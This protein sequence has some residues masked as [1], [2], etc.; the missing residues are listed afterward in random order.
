MLIWCI[1]VVFA[2]PHFQLCMA[3]EADIGSQQEEEA[4][5]KADEAYDSLE[6][7]AS[8]GIDTTKNRLGKM[9]VSSDIGSKAVRGILQVFYKIYQAVKSVAGIL[10][11]VSEV[12]GTSIYVLFKKDKKIKRLGLFG[13][14][15][16]FPLII[17]AVVYGIGILNG[18]FLNVKDPSELE[19]TQ[20]YMELINCYGINKPA[21]GTI[22]ANGLNGVHKVYQGMRHVAWL[23]IIAFESVGIL[24]AVFGKYK[25]SKRRT[26]ILGYCIAIPAVLLLLIFGAEPINRIFLS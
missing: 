20:Q 4:E 10:I 12:I 24:K 1:A 15:V 17:V 23:L 16:I 9:S 26:G 7:S 22:L 6:K 2:V 19:Y 18:L 11:L 8:K 21:G 14:C 25:K 5:Q 13:F 3:A